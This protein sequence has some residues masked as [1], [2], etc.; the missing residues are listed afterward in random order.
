MRNLLLILALLVFFIGYSADTRAQD[1]I[2]VPNAL[3]MVEGNNFSSLPLACG[4]DGFNSQRYQQIYSAAELQT[5][6]ITEIRFRLDPN[7]FV[8]VPATIQDLQ[9]N[10]AIT[11]TDPENASTTFA[12]NIGSDVQTVFSG[13]LNVNPP[14]CLT[15]P[16]PFDIVLPITPY[17]YSTIQGNLLLDIT[18]NECSGLTVLFDTTNNAQTSDTVMNRIYSDTVDGADDLTG[19]IDS[20]RGL[21]TEFEFQPPTPRNVPTL[22]E[23]GLI[24]MAGLLGIVGFYVVSRRKVA[25]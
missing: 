18:V 8:I 22:S 17:Q 4:A 10:L 14:Q 1:D 9:I 11:Q 7:Q 16:C 13:D 3:A 25:A 5:G 2:V 21:I 12:N 24:A 23:W 6:Q 20:T 15:T 19:V